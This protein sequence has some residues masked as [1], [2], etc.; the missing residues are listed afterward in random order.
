MHNPF[1]WMKAKI[2]SIGQDDPGGGMNPKIQR[3]YRL[4]LKVY[5]DNKKVYT[6][7][8]QFDTYVM[9][10]MRRILDTGLEL[11]DG[12]YKNKYYPA[13]RIR[14]VTVE[15]EDEKVCLSFCGIMWEEGFYTLEV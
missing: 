13:H 10:E 4:T 14:L 12:A 6:M 9:Q 15:S 5:L 3:A 1:E 7:K 8:S 2:E 11:P